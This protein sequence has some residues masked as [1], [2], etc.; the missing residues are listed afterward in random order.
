VYF[1]KRLINQLTIDI[2][3]IVKVL[4]QG[5]NAVP[6][7]LGDADGSGFFITVI[8]QNLSSGAKSGL[9]GISWPLLFSFVFQPQ[10]L[11]STTVVYVRVAIG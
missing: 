7:T 4:I 8:Y 10:N 11:L 5:A 9:Y 2:F 1:G 6:G 3:F